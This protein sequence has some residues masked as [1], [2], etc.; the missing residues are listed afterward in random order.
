MP[1]ATGVPPPRRTKPLPHRC[2]ATSVSSCRRYLARRAPR[3]SP[4]LYPPLPHRL[5]DRVTAGGRARAAPTGSGRPGHCG[6]W[7][8]P[9]LQGHGPNSGPTRFMHL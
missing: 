8:G 3:G 4:V 9:V 6:R 1:L 7:A 5:A 2:N